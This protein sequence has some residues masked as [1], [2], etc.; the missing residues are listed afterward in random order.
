MSTPESTDLLALWG[1]RERRA[2]VW[3][4]GWVGVAI[5]AYSSQFLTN[6][7]LRH[8]VEREFGSFNLQE[9]HRLV[10]NHLPLLLTT[11][12]ILVVSLI[13]FLISMV[14]WLLAMSRRRQAERQL[15]Q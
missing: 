12:I 5:W 1:S 6:L 14:R 9:Y 11:S 7:W 15:F 8:A 13:S 10:S 3:T 2:F 4:C